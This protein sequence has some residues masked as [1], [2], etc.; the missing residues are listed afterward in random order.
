MA[1]GRHSLGPFLVEMM[2]RIGLLEYLVTIVETTARP[3]ALGE[4]A[5]DPS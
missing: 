2:R 3:I 5:D 1:S 4:H